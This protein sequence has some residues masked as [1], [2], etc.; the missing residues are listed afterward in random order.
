MHARV[1]D[2]PAGLDT[3][4]TIKVASIRIIGYLKYGHILHG[5]QKRRHTQK[6]I[7]ILSEL[8]NSQIESN[9]Y[10]CIRRQ[11]LRVTPSFELSNSET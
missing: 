9:I 2:S 4:N 10:M 1:M 5:N 8:S 3:D 7:F 11:V 6:I